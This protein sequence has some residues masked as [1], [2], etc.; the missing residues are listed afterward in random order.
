MTGFLYSGNRPE[1]RGVV[2]AERKKIITSDTG[3]KFVL[4]HS[5]DEVLYPFAILVPGRNQT[6][7][8]TL[9]PRVAF[10]LAASLLTFQPKRLL[11][12]DCK[13]LLYTFQTGP[14]AD[15][16]KRP[17]PPK[18]EKPRLKK[19]C[20]SSKV[21]SRHQAKTTVKPSSII[22]SKQPDKSPKRKLE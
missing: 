14:L 19:T 17:E 11:R 18:T 10:R 8:Y 20:R 12:P 6:R 3:L 22:G 7:F 5:F 16:L 4:S 13:S 9:V 2:V 21:A 15:W 1:Y